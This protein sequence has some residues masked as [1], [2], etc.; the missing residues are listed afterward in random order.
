MPKN[1][2]TLVEVGAIGVASALLLWAGGASATTADAPWSYSGATG[3]SHWGSLSPAYALCADGTAQSPINIQHP[4]PMPLR[5]LDFDYVASEAEV[6][7]N[8]HTVEAEPAPGTP[9][10]TLE[11]DNVDYT[12]TQFHFHSPSEHT[13]NGRRYPVEIH[14]VNKAADGRIAVVG[15]FLKLGAP[16]NSDWQKFIDVISQATADPEQTVIDKLNWRKLL[17]TRQQTVRY[18][19]S[20]T[21]PGCS[22]GVKWS[23]M[24]H[25][26]TMSAQQLAVFEAAYTGN[27]RPTQPLNGRTVLIDSTPSH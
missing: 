1:P 6:F 8:G 4:K 7:N 15:V 27:V 18:D 26:L 14:F 3:P 5:N 11:L 17:P 23:V 12:F 24:T 16:A 10:S 19:G 21:T 13:I 25:P 22:E 20:L 2:R 9:P